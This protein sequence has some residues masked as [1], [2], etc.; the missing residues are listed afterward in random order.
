MRS[1]HTLPLLLG[2]TLAAAL[3]AATP[4]EAAACGGTFCDVGPQP[5]PVDQTGENI[6]FVINGQQVEAHI[7]IQYDPD[8]DADKFA[9]VIPVQAVP[10]FAVGSEQL[11]TNMLSG[12]V[13]SYQLNTTFAACGDE[14]DTDSVNFGGTAG[15]YGSD[16][17]GGT[18]MGSTGDPGPEV[19]LTTTV[20]AFDISVLEG[21]TTETLMQWLGDNGYQQDPDAAPIFDEYLKE[22]HLFAAFK[23]TTG[24]GADQIHPVV[25]TF[26]TGEACIPLRLTRIAAQEDMEVRA[27]FLGN[28]RV[29]PRSYRHVLINPLKIDWL[30]LANIAANYKE[31]ITQAVDAL[32][33]D[34]HGFVTEYAGPSSAVLPFN[35]VSSS[36]Y[37]SPIAAV[38]VTSVVDILEDQGIMACYG[39]DTCQYFHPLIEGLLHEYVPIPDGVTEGAFYSCLTCF[40]GL[41]DQAAWDGPAM[42][43]AYQERIIA[44]GQHAVD[45]LNTWPYLTRM[46]TT[47]SPGEMTVDPFF[48]ENQQLGDVMNV[49]VASSRVLCNG[50][51]IVTLPDDRKVYV[52]DGQGWPAFVDELPYEEDI[53]EVMASGAP[54]NLV[55]NTALIDARLAQWNAQVNADGGFDE[56]SD[57]SSDGEGCGCRVQSGVTGT[58]VGLSAL[59]LFGLVARRRRR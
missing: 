57:G 28:A 13:P 40:E 23:L 48:H 47:I 16:S 53:E 21:G 35:L 29:A 37:S 8:T 15:G 18:T 17:D 49:Q 44:P 58:A 10:Q 45:L 26:D 46:Y 27:F 24:A 22:G 6:L 32:K 14:G 19:L 42:A 12:T 38:S 39:G 56:S 9:W 25:L 54:V 3:V 7:Q 2:S 34:G 30:N 36:W 51:Q 33:S 50:N 4:Q 43:A 41:I 31:V 11:F 5:M 20:G 59:L 1:A 55:D 52:P